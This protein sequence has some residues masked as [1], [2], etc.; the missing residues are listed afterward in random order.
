MHYQSCTNQAKH[1]GVKVHIVVYIYSV[2]CIGKIHIFDNFSKSFGPMW[3]K[4]NI[5]DPN[6]TRALKVER[7][8][9]HD[10]PSRD[11]TRGRLGFLEV[12]K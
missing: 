5:H 6:M 1:F 2:I 12:I 10:G 8:G 4:L 9:G 7:E 3:N 11:P